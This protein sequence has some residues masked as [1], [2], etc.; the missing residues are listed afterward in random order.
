M[1]LRWLANNYLREAAETHLRDAVAGTLQPAARQ[2]PGE[3]APP[4][5]VAFVFALGIEA[6]G[7]IDKLQDSSTARGPSFLEHSGVIGGKEIVIA[8]SGMGADAA[9]KTTA[10]VIEFHQPAWVVSAGFAG[11]LTDDLKRGHF[12]MADQVV[13]L[14]GRRLDVGLKLAPETVAATKGLHVGRLLTV[15]RLI[16]TQAHK[17]QLNTAHAAVA[18]DMETFAVAE[19]CRKLGTRFLSV[20][21]ISDSVEDELSK[22][23]ERL[24]KQTTLTGKLGAA[25]K[26]LISRPQSAAEMWKLQEDALKASDRLAK[27]LVSMLPQLVAKPTV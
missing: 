3:L 15:D 21:V 8:E 9:A 24:M 7:L 25:A 20:R 14:A 16:R 1:L 26:A 13:D 17:R 5:D 2:K 11:A 19:T 10:D 6:G 18:C 12:L 4:C 22:E 27:Y 23:I